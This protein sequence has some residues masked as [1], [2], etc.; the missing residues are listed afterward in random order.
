MNT[1]K[2][3]LLSLLFFVVSCY[4]GSASATIYE[5]NI[6][7]DTY[8]Y[9]GVYVA[10]SINVGTA[11]IDDTAT[12]TYEDDGVTPLFYYY[13]LTY[14]TDLDGE[15]YD[16]SGY[17]GFINYH[18]DPYIF[19]DSEQWEDFGYVDSAFS[20]TDWE[21]PKNPFKFRLPEEMWNLDIVYDYGHYQFGGRFRLTRTG[22][23]N[24]PEP[25][26]LVLISLGLVGLAFSGRKK[27]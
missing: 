11:L 7:S 3:V 10:E 12:I 9:D 17:L 27:S 16:G 14:H 2:Q 21:T 15:V 23:V 8:R 20:Y 13:D 18:G 25:A 6:S 1:P 22:V 4:A 5:Y 24:V 19:G 26:S